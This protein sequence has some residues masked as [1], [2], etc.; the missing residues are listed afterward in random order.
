MFWKNCCTID[1]VL[2]VVAGIVEDWPDAVFY[3]CFE[4]V[5]W[6]PAN[7]LDR[8]DSTW[9]VLRE[10]QKAISRGEAVQSW[11]GPR[12]II[13]LFMGMFLPFSGVLRYA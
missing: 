3:G 7:L 11:I 2:E 4:F 8:F 5:L 13:S 9:T 10:R 1:G 6:F 12:R